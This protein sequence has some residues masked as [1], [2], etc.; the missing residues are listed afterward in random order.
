MQKV[1]LVNS[2]TDTLK[3]IPKLR[4]NPDRAS[5]IRLLRHPARKRSG[6]VPTRMITMYVRHCSV[7]HLRNLDTYEVVVPRRVDRE[8]SSSTWVVG[9]QKRSSGNDD[10]DEG[11]GSPSYAVYELSAFGRRMSLRL[12]LSP[13]SLVS[14]SYVVQHV[15]D[16][17][18]WLASPAASDGSS[19]A[20]RW[21]N[22]FHEGHVDG[23][24]QSVVV[25]S[26]CPQLV[27]DVI[28]VSDSDAVPSF[29]HVSVC[30]CAR[31]RVCKINGKPK[32]QTR[33]G[34]GLGP[35]MGWVGLGPEILGWVGF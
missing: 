22:C 30:V 35:S 26:T 18:T 1:A 11:D 34:H 29:V 3:N 19:P 23:D 32:R 6:S 20:D 17:A 15:A 14:P 27:S 16:N 25:L 8:S 13:T 12:R 24:P 5:F 21:R 31:A 4:D 10:D 9:R 2:T 33:V 28:P 7:D